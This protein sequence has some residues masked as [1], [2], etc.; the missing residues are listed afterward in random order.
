[1]LLMDGF[2][3]HE[4]PQFIWY[5]TMF[6]NIPYQLPSHTSLLLQPFDVGVYQHLKHTQRSA[7]Y[8]FIGGG[9]LQL[10]RF[11]FLGM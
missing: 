2:S 7:L 10:S 8:D 1:M 6:D 9:G 5:C 3:V 4:D 11:Q